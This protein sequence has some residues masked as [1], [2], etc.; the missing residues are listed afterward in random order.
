MVA[1]VVGYKGQILTDPSKLDG[2]PRKLMD[3][4]RLFS[5]GWKPK[6]SIEN[7][8]ID[9]YKDFLRRTR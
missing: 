2:T 5:M 1:D 7:G 4:S 8:L 6:I 9:T 3:S